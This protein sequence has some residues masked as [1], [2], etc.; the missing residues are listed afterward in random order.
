MLVVAPVT[1]PGCPGM[2]EPIA[3]HLA[4]L[5][6]QALVAVTQTGGAPV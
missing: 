3:L 6:P 5:V 4:A 2:L 1:D